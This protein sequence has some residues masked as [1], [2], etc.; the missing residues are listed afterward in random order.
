MIGDQVED[1]LYRFFGDANGDR[2]VDGG[3]V[4]LLIPTLFV[5]EGMPG[6]NGSFDFNGDAAV[7]GG[8][9]GALIPNLFQVLPF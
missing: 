9:I 2:A 6:Y 1:G 7:D 4:G 8:D 5:S 3:D